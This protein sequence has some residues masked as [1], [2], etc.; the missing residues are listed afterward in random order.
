MNS[1]FSRPRKIVGRY[2]WSRRAPALSRTLPIAQ[3]TT[4]PALASLFSGQV[5]LSALDL[6]CFGFAVVDASGRVVHVNRMMKGILEKRDGLLLQCDG[7]LRLSEREGEY[8]LGRLQ[9]VTMLSPEQQEFVLTIDRPS[10]KPPW[11]VFIRRLELDAQDHCV[12][13]F[14]HDPHLACAANESAVRESWGLTACEARIA[15]RLAVGKTIEDCSKEL[16]VSKATVRT[17]L[18]NLFRKC[19]VRRQSELI[20]LL[21]GTAGLLQ[22]DH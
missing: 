18:Q 10:E 12:L 15:V 16:Q 19:G 20:L 5:A 7:A 14:F 8:L 22:P 11:V 17:H 9:F 3:E 4:G 6:M 13:L 1:L 21:A 2:S